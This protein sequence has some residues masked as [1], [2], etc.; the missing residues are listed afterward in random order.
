MGD[1]MITRRDAIA[2]SA[3]A[4]L[5]AGI[6]GSSAIAVAAPAG[7]DPHADARLMQLEQR[8]ERLVRLANESPGISDQQ[9]ARIGELEDAVDAEIMATPAAGVDGLLVKWRRVRRWS[10]IT[11]N[12]TLR[13]H[14]RLFEAELVRLVGRAA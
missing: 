10:E 7:A 4:A 9:I 2:T 12:I 13:D 5:A 8:M 3:A 6:A 11:F 14:A 1:P